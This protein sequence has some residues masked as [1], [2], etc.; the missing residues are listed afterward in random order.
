VY[1]ASILKVVILL[2][3]AA[4]LFMTGLIWFVQIVH[5][6][7]FN[8]VGSEGFTAYET[9]H[10]TLTTFVVIVPMVVELVTAF[11]LLWQRPEGIALWQLWVGLLLVGVIWLSTALLQV[12]Q[13][14]V[15]SQGFDETAYGMLV[16]SNWLRTIAWTLRS[17]LV[18]YWLSSKMTN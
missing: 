14:G 11:A 10:S 3:A 1:S 17:V 18:L 6:P 5:Y 12:P 16:S 7:L 15:L 9:R 2:N 8:Q 4:T 13:H